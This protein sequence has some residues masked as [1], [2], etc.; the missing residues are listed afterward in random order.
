VLVGVEYKEELIM[1]SQRR[2]VARK[3]S[4]EEARMCGSGG[5]KNSIGLVVLAASAVA[6][7]EGVVDRLLGLKM[8]GMW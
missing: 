5:K 6:E 7:M 8:V 3:C 1:M 4:D 2:G